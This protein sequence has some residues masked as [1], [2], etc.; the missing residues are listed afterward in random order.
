MKSSNEQR[1]VNEFVVVDPEIMD[2]L[3]TLK[4]TR[5]PVYLIL[6]MIEDGNSLEDVRK[7][8]P[9]LTREQIRAAIHYAAE[10]VSHAESI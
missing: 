9:F 5:I 8:Y 6:E 2:G 1:P 7:E 10:R 4:G 3:P